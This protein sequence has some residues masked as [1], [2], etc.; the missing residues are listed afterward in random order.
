MTIVMFVSSI[1]E[2]LEVIT[3]LSNLQI[4]LVVR[5]FACGDSQSGHVGC[6][7]TWRSDSAARPLAWERTSF[8]LAAGREGKRSQRKTLLKAFNFSVTTDA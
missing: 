8:S 6:C 7:L 1:L 5:T 3:T 4:P 2:T